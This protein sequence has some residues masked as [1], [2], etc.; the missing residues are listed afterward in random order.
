MG[1]GARSIKSKK[2]MKIGDFGRFD[3]P[4]VLFGGPYS[5]FQALEAMLA[6]IGD[7]P[8]ICTG[9]IVAYCADPQDTV[10]LFRGAG[11]ATIAGNC[12]RQVESLAEDCGCGFADGSACD[13]MSAGWWPYL[14]D[15]LGPDD[16]A[17]FATLPDIAT[18]VHEDR[19]Y[20]VVH[21]GGS[22]NSR[23]LW[24]STSNADL[25]HEIEMVEALTG[26]IDGII[27][28]HS[29]IAFQRQVGRHHWIN[30]GVIG[31]PPHDGRTQTRYSVLDQGEAVVH[32]LSFD[33]ELARQRMEVNGLTQGY[34]ETLT[35][36]IWPSEDVLP[37]S[38]RR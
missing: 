12:E 15:A 38:L 20:A 1:A 29:G 23:F 19:R 27:A 26:R 25:A 21:G 14:R 30:P 3:G 32:R 13:L 9:D 36:G 7:R 10:A 5:N 4:L 2:A 31:L 16:R 35:T 18:F 6:A 8:S 34:H 24:P 28:G 22:S 11:V 33:H 37:D 17:W